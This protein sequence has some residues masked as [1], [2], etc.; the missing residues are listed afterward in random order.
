MVNTVTGT[1]SANAL[2]KTLMHEHI[3]FGYP[4]FQGDSTLGGWNKAIALKNI[5]HV[6]M[7][8][9]PNGG[10]NEVRKV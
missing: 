2:G 3:Q 10:T 4:G 7:N 5:K 6:L 1:I 9:L 8:I